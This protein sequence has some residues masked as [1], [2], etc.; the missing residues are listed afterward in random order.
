M[1]GCIA[2]SDGLNGSPGRSSRQQQSHS[3]GLDIE[4]A[5]FVD[6]GDSNLLIETGIRRRGK[7]PTYESL[8]TCAMI[9]TCETASLKNLIKHTCVT[10]V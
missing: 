7:N 3:I 5:G 2:V 4:G 1:S 9:L 8:P 10:S 6:P